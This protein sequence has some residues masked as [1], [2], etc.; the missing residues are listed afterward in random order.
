MIRLACDVSRRFQ[1]YQMILSLLSFYSLKEYLVRTDSTDTFDYIISDKRGILFFL[2][3]TETGS[4]LS[5]RRRR[6]RNLSF[7]FFYFISS[8]GNLHVIRRIE[9]N[10]FLDKANSRSWFHLFLDCCAQWNRIAT[11][12]ISR[13]FAY[14]A[15]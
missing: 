3:Y 5:R 13:C 8:P 7:L 10:K 15:I 12:C 11:E 9:I 1:Y 2:I 6:F 14:I 4:R